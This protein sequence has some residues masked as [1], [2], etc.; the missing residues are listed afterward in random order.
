MVGVLIE[1]RSYSKKKILNI[2]I[3]STRENKEKE[4]IFLFGI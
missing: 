3:V 2:K 4:R 1:Q